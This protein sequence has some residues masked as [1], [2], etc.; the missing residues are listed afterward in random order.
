MRVVRE[1]KFLRQYENTSV[2]S[3]CCMPRQS[4][5]S[6]TIT[7]SEDQIHRVNSL[8]RALNVF[9]AIK[10]SFQNYM[11]SSCTQNLH[12][13][14]KRHQIEVSSKSSSLTCQLVC[15]GI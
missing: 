5:S 13:S 15:G 10:L 12:T 3:T 1:P 14:D 9:L 6:N 8:T 7:L 4:K 11:T 2:S